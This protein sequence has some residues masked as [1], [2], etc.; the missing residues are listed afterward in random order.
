MIY[1]RILF[2]LLIMGLLPFSVSAKKLYKYQDENGRW[3]FSDKP[4]K[5]ERPVEVKQLKPV[6]KQLVR[7]KKIGARTNPQF[8][9]INDYGGT[10]E[11]RAEFSEQLNF[12]SH[13]PL[14][15]SFVVKPGESP[16]LFKLIRI[17]PRQKASYN[18]EYRYTLGSPLAKH[19]PDAVYLP[20][21]AKGKR[22]WIS[23]GFNGAFSH[24]GKENRYAVDLTMPEG[25]PI[26]AARAGV[27]M[28]VNEDFYENGLKDSLKS[29]SNNIRILHDDGSIA[30]YAHL[31]VDASLVYPGLKVKAGQLIGYSGNTGFSTGP[32]LHFAV[33]VNT[34]MSTE[35]VPFQF[36]DG[37]GRTMTPVA[38]A[39]L[40]ND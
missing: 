31:K 40:V 28:A 8:L 27:V 4:P 34:G 32:H 37:K 39:W 23:Q 15:Q 36:A 14:P 2:F 5:T 29:K 18:V 25:T 38:K 6:S 7:L 10:I 9:I 21:F 24:S 33:H 35:S 17:N 1:K 3:H 26:H 19:D 20:P 13:P 22:F 11:V 16:V 30:M 12:V